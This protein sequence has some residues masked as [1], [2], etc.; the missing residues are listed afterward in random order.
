MPV[1]IRRTSTQHSPPSNWHCPSKLPPCQY[2]P[3]VDLS[4]WML[5]GSTPTSNLNS[6]RIPSPQNTSTISQTVT[7]ECTALLNW[8]FRGV[9]DVGFSLCAVPTYYLSPSISDI[10]IQNLRS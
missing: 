9:L 5:K 10:G 7:S 8:K 3:S 4:S 1:S 6:E 2:Q